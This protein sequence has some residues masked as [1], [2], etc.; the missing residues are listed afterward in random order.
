M[1]TNWVSLA[2]GAWIFISGWIPAVQSEWNLIIFGV[3]AAVFGFAS[4]KNWQ[5]IVNGVAGIWLFLCGIWFMIMAP[6]N[7]LITGIVMV[8]LGLWGALYHSHTGEVTHTA[9]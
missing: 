7:F 4:Y 3:L 1:W 8:L 2:I 5:G 6:A 9:A